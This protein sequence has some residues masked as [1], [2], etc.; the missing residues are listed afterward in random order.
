[1][2][3]FNVDLT[4]YPVEELPVVEPA[5][6][7][8]IAP[9][10]AGAWTVAGDLD[11]DG[12][13][14]LV[15][16]RLWEQN[17]T[18]AVAAV[19][20]Y[21][22]D[23]SVLWR[24]GNPA[25]GVAALHSDAPCQIHDWNCDGRPEVVLATRTHVVV[26]DGATGA[27]LWRFA[28]PDPEAADCLV[29]ARLSGAERDDVLLK[30]RYHRIWAYTW[31]GRLLWT[32]TD[33]GGMKTAHQPYPVDLDGDG[34]DAIIAGYAVL[35]HDGKLLWALDGAALQLG[36][37]HLDCARVLQ[38]GPRPEDW[39][40]AFACCGDNALLCLDGR[41]RL[42]WEQRGLHFES[43]FIGPMI[44]GCADR[45]LVVD[46][47]DYENPSPS[48]LQVYDL[49]GM[50][51]G[52]MNT[53]SSRLH[54]LTSWGDEPVE[55]IVACE[56]RLLVSGET[57]VPMARFATLLPPGTQFDQG[58]RPKDH[59]I[60]GAFHVLGHVGN[61]F[62]GSGQDL[63]LTTNP[64]GVIWLYRNPG[65]GLGTMPLGTGRNVTLY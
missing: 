15:Q 35:N 18:H 13:V 21:R 60:R 12:Q 38:R 31:D 48:P 57:G 19:S 33:P 54:P 25:E 36:R 6:V 62:G 56:D 37:G 27:E 14:E 26:L 17:D 34:R 30:D 45:Q 24:W 10:Y 58:E 41:G 39:R 46:I 9:E 40:L 2:K 43:L 29:F 47:V 8:A 50:L 53:A 22:L 16:A 28:T 11:G 64:G 61:L 23:G 7:I 49:N 55:R 4:T 52:E 32:V 51:L 65:S 3:M 59:L 44:P 42:V 63:M 20:A 5:A 1:M